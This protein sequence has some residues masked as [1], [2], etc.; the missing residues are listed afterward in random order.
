MIWSRAVLAGLSYWHVII[1]SLL[2]S[3]VG[4]LLE[5]FERNPIV[6]LLLVVISPGHS[7]ALRLQWDRCALRTLLHDLALLQARNAFKTEI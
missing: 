2:V 3:S 5:L 1:A 7:F 6:L 4:I